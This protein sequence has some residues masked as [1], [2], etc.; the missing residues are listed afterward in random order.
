M[1]M[2]TNSAYRP[3]L[4]PY[5]LPRYDAITTTTVRYDVVTVTVVV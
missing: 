1:V 5:P 3:T 4:V 2:V